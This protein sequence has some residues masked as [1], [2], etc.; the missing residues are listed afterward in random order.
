[1][2]IQEAAEGVIKYVNERDYVTMAEIQKKLEGEG[3]P[4]KG[5]KG[6]HANGYPNIL[7]WFDMSDEFCDV[8]QIVIKG[9]RRAMASPL[10]YIADGLYPSIP[11]AKNLRQ[12]KTERWV[13]VCFRPKKPS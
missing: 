13:P 2:N 5:R 3:F 6:L 7:L 12:Y 9:T 11:I 8:M 10:S 4:V 1:M